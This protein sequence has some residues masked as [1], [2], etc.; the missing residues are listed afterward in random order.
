MKIAIVS[1]SLNPGSRSR[2]MA[3]E[4]RTRLLAR[5]EV[6]VDFIDLREMEL[7]LCDGG[8]A[9]GDPY[10]L[11]LNKRLEAA[12][13]YVLA[14]PIYN[15]DVNAA[16]KNAIELAGRN[17]ENKLV[18][19]LCAAGGAMSY[20]SVMPLANSLMLDFRVIVLPRFVYSVPED[21]TGDTMSP[22]VSDRISQFCE[23]LATLGEKLAR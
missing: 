21:W 2:M 4:V 1:S 23:A 11:D 13:A 8:A 15:Y 16:L 14:S 7:P 3:L 12:D 5:A 10:A 19:F 22:V 20:M 18:G 6:E 9:Y 17:M